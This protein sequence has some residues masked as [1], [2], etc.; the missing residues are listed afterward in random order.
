VRAPEFGAGVAALLI[1][2]FFAV[3]GGS[4]GFLSV[5]GTASWLNTASQLGIIAVPL[6]L[7]MISG[8]FDLSIGSMVG[9]GSVTVGVVTGYLHYGLWLAVII[10]AAVALA[11]GVGN[12]L[13]VTRTAVHSFIVTLAAN[14]IVAGLGLTVS[15]AVTGTTSI[16]VRV[17]GFTAR[18]FDGQWG[19]LSISVLWWALVAVVGGWVLAKTRS[20][21][22]ITATGGDHEQ[23]RRAGVA[24]SRVTVGLFVCTAL[25]SAFVGVLQAVQ[26]TTGDPTTGQSYVFEAAIVVVI[27]GVLISGGYGS[28]LGVVLGTLIYGIADAGLFYTGW[29]TNYAEILIG[30]LMVIAVL[31]NNFLRRLATTTARERRTP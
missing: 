12:G 27:G 21:N 19:Q 16:P 15:L 31:T 20:G 17:T 24:T 14:L 30:A 23:A 22:W 11:V 26:Y 6:G 8:S 3:V 1:Y 4:K 9:A 10:A 18:L 28:I 25:A 13:L 7:L 29:D 5:T 2:G